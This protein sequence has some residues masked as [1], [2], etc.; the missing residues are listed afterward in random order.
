MERQCGGGAAA[1]A[2]PGAACPGPGAACAGLDVL[3]RPEVAA[4][5]VDASRVILGRRLGAGAHATVYAATLLPRGGG[6]GGGAAEGA[7]CAGGADGGAEQQAAAGR[8]AGGRLI[9][10][11]LDRAGPS[12]LG[13]VANEIA[14]LGLAGRH[15]N[16]VQL[17][18][19]FW[20]P[21]GAQPGAAAA[22]AAGG[23]A[24]GGGGCDDGGGGA[25]AAAG[26]GATL[27]LLLERLE[28]GTLGAALKSR[29][30]GAAEGQFPE[31]AVMAWFVQLLL[32]LER[33]HA[34]SVC[35]R[36][37]KPDNIF[38]CGG[39]RLLKLGDLGVSKLLEAGALAKT[40]LGTPGYTAPE[41][42]AGR[43]YSTAS[44]IWAAGC[45]LLEAA[46]RRPAFDA[47]GVPQL[48][49]KIMRGAY[50]LPPGLCA[51]ARL[52]MPLMLRPD[53]GQ[54]PAARDLLRLRPPGPAPAA[55][56]A[57]PVET[58]AAGARRPVAARASA[59]ALARAWDSDLKFKE[60]RRQLAERRYQARQLEQRRARE[61]AR[62]RR[63]E[64]EAPPG[65]ELAPA[66]AEEAWE[67]DAARGCCLLGPEAEA[68]LGL[69]V[70]SLVAEGSIELDAPAEGAAEAAAGAAAGGGGSGEAAAAAAG[71]GAGAAE[72]RRRLRQ[73]EEDLEAALAD[74]DGGGAA[75]AGAGDGR[76]QACLDRA[77]AAARRP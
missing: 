30:G 58:R 49:L 29:A 22:D 66:G 38:L 15:P 27:C 61:E 60:E 40:R 28:G 25:A 26:G 69:I 75:A 43:P 59:P 65:G 17:R 2:A 23:P 46:T 18:G 50:A 77:Y 42:L 72:A 54:R 32:A 13:Q 33:L 47:R 67:G 57:A 16:I 1:A 71:E 51:P 7:A 11:C 14:L 21:W 45:V 64:L 19:W 12:L 48:I 76:L 24:A 4:L 36:D 41:V 20:Q 9:A 34:R 31:A 37:V 8:P 68:E 63:Q 10:K 5:Q 73:L 70:Q 53:P 39:H 62:Q 56:S 44:D 55:D 35:H 74:A 3:L 6:G 52:L